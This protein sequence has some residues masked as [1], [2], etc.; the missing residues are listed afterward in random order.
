MDART[1][2]FLAYVQEG[3]QVEAT[4]W[5]PGE[6]RQ[7]LIKFIE[8]HANSELMGVLPERDGDP[9]GGQPAEPGRSG[10]VIIDGTERR[11]QRPKTAE[12]QTLH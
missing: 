9:L 2:E 8:M 6:Y 1:E 5:L 4:D 10:L 3:G 11:R 7:K 12:K